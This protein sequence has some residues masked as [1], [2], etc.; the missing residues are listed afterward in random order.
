MSGI[1]DAP[2]IS[3]E[4]VQRADEAF[5]AET[6]RQQ[7]LYPQVPLDL[8]AR[9]RAALEAVAT[10]RTFTGEFPPAGPQT[11]DDLVVELAASVTRVRIKYGAAAVALSKSTGVP[12]R[13]VL[14]ALEAGTAEQI[15]E[16][17]GEQHVTYP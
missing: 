7:R 5:T 8:P 10:A 3:D 15:A 6:L 9:M 17:L 13:S 14:D 4:M 2:V 12:V 1:G 16:T 11:V